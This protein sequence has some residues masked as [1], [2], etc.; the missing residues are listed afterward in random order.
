MIWVFILFGSIISL[1]YFGRRDKECLAMPSFLVAL[2]SAILLALFVSR[3]MTTY[4]RLVGQLHEVKALQQRISDIVTA[5]YPEQPGKLIAGSLTNFQQ[6]S[7]L[8]DYFRQVAREEAV[9][10]SMLARAWVYKRDYMWVIFGHGFFISSKVF[11][12]PKVE[13]A[14]F[15]SRKIR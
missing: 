3:G 12:L 6:S 5:V 11:Q 1:V 13:N 7:K 14:G 2:V 4:P 15:V 10:N 9:Y 8:S